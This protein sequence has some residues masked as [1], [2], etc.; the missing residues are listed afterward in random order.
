MLEANES[1]ESEEVVEGESLNQLLV[2]VSEGSGVE[3]GI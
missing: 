1:G 2:P 3:V